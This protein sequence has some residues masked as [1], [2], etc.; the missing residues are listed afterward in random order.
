MPLTKLFITNAIII[1]S[2]CEAVF[3]NIFS[4]F[5]DFISFCFVF[6]IHSLKRNKNFMKKKMLNDD[7]GSEYDEDL[8]EVDEN[9]I[10]VSVL[11]AH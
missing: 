3:H 10:G 4:L 2:F 1:V 6:L 8:N 9:Y 7:D 11:R 5:F